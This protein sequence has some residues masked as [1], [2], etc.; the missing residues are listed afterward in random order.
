MGSETDSGT[1]GTPVLPEHLRNKHLDKLVEEHFFHIEDATLNA[2]ADLGTLLGDVKVVLMG[3]A[4][5]RAEKIAE[6][7]STAFG[8][9]V[10]PLGMRERYS[11]FKVGPVISMNHGIGSP[12][13][14]IILHELTKV[15]QRAGCKD[16]TYIRMG[17]SGGIGVTPG[18]IVVTCE[19]VNCELESVYEMTVLGKR[20]RFPAVFDKDLAEELAAVGKRLDFPVL[21]AKTMATDDYYEEQG[22]LDGAVD[23]QYSE[24][25]K[26]EWIQKVYEYGV[27]NMEME[28][29]ALAAFCN[30]T[31]VRAAMVCAAL[32]DRTKGD[33]TPDQASPE[34]MGQWVSNSQELVV[35]WLRGKF[36]PLTTAA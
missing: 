15:L 32:L 6:R 2:K 28:G 33:Q 1:Q 25:E 8:W 30:R 10:Q 18:T 20:R 23:C 9:P 24:S 34:Q 21:V 27:R 36:A 13:L 12:S 5:D 29:T 17:T 4:A 35:E 22:R 7:L 31:G 14:M 11:L 3:G 26:M 19:G 16:V